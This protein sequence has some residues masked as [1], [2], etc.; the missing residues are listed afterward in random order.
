MDSSHP[1]WVGAW[2]IGFLSSGVLGFLVAIP[3]SGFPID[4]PGECIAFVNLWDPHTLQYIRNINKLIELNGYELRSNRV[5]L[6]THLHK[7]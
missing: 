3:L 4:L 6:F 7:G 5:L 1:K 2:W